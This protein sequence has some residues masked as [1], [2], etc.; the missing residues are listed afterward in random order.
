MLGH[1]PTYFFGNSMSIIRMTK[2]YRLSVLV[3]FDLWP[4]SCLRIMYVFPCF[5]FS[6]SSKYDCN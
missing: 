3:P 6:R 5:V 4:F 2:L 1:F